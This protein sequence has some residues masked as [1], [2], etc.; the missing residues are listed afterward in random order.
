MTRGARGTILTGASLAQKKLLLVDADPRSLRVIEVSLRKAGYN[1]TCA[2]DGNA[3]LATLEHQLP[4]L[5]IADTTLTELDGYGFVR[6]LRDRAE[7]SALPVIFLASQLAVEDKIRG[8]ELGVEEYLAKPVFVRELLARVDVVLARRAQ[9]RLSD[10]H[11]EAESSDRVV[12]STREMTVIDLLQ[13]F[14]VSRKS[15]SITFSRGGPIGNLWFDAGSLVDAETGNLRGEEAV[16]RMLVW[17]DADFEITFSQVQREARVDVST[18]AL[19]MEGM[20]RADEWGRLTEQLP[21]LSS[22]L[23]VDHEKLI[24]RLSEIPDELNGILRLLDG[25]RSLMEVIDASP[26]EDLSTLTTLSKLYFEGLLVPSKASSTMPEAVVAVTRSAVG[27]AVAPPPRRSTSAR[28]LPA[29][30]G[31]HAAATTPP[32]PVVARRSKTNP[33]PALPLHGPS[34]QVL[35]LRLATMPQSPPWVDPASTAGPDTEPLVDD[36]TLRVLRQQEAAIVAVVED[37]SAAQAPVAE[38]SSPDTLKEPGYD[39]PESPALGPPWLE[40]EVDAPTPKRASGKAVAIGLMS[41]TFAFAAAAL[42]ARYSY[43]GDH[44]TAAGL[45]LPLRNSSDAS[46]VRDASDAGVLPVQDT[47]VSLEPVRLPEAALGPS[48][49]STRLTRASAPRPTTVTPP[50]SPVRPALPEGAGVGS[51]ESLTQEA[52]KALERE[53]DARSASRAA[54]LAAKATRRDPTNAEAWLTLG[55]AYHNLGNKTQE[56]SAYRSCAKLATGPR[57]SECRALAGLPGE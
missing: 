3:A 55:G 34:G 27:P 48:R 4:D 38:A 28:P 14:E 29:P 17:G 5:V 46:D 18:S 13:T 11:L 57:V 16:Y 45:G 8:L 12:G 6:C 10:P 26:F 56:M 23:D 9:E 19:V 41:V 32:P 35:T 54:D 22:T 47:R 30:P 50:S 39:D 37:V 40:D 44:D 25:T 20:R 53:G 51:S 24:D 21:P 42:Y 31:A 49:E 43:R 33:P 36:D 7:W 15:G 52:Q 2:S 1:V